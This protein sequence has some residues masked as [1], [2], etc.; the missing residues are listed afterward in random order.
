MPGVV[1]ITGMVHGILFVAFV[2]SLLE[3]MFKYRWTLV[4][5]AYVFASSLVP[6]GTFVIDYTLLRKNV[7]TRA[8]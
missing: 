8:T 5:S 4:R 2:V 7:E 6:F 1:R 3:V